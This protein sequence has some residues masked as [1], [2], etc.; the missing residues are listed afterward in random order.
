M[1]ARASSAYRVDGEPL[2]GA[3]HSHCG[4]IGW[5]VPTSKTIVLV[6]FRL[7]STRPLGAAATTMVFREPLV[8]VEKV[9]VSLVC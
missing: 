2:T 9:D 7:E 1:L 4:C 3:R 8:P 5:S 6:S